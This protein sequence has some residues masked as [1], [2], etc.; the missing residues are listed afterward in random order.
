MATKAKTKISTLSLDQ[1]AALLPK[2]RYDNEEAFELR[3]LN[4]QDV[5]PAKVL[6]V[7]YAPDMDMLRF[8]LRVG[9]PT[10]RCRVWL[11]RSLISLTSNDIN[12]FIELIR[13]VATLGLLQ[14]VLSPSASE[15]IN[16]SGNA[17]LFDE[18]TVKVQDRRAVKPK[19]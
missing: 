4:G 10:G 18:H 5:I 7:E 15:L 8:N 13:K 16:K 9:P 3:W 14:I 12:N 1:I 2:P 11:K 19:G 6:Y 17:K